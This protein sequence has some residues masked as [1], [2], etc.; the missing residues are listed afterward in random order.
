MSVPPLAPLPSG[1]IDPSQMPLDALARNPH[2]S[3]ET[4]I[5]EATRQFEAVLLRQILTEARKTVIRSDLEESSS[6]SAIYDDLI[7]Q[8]LADS[9]SRSGMLGLAD[10]LKR[11]FARPST[12]AELT[13]GTV[14][15][16]LAGAAAGYPAS[17]TPGPSH[18]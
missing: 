13:E 3:E 12:A 15:G 10:L 9:I 7:N 2:V 17:L 6:V 4:K 1:P 8:T 18:D 14:S 11:Q 5:G 16:S